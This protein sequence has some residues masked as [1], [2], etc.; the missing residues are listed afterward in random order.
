MYSP[1]FNVNIDG[2]LAIAIYD[3]ATISLSDSTILDFS[4]SP[5]VGFRSQSDVSL[6]VQPT[7]YSR[8]DSD[9]TGT[10]ATSSYSSHHDTGSPSPRNTPP[11]SSTHVPTPQPNTYSHLDSDVTGA[12]A[13]SSYSSHH[14]TGSPS[15]PYGSPAS[16]THVPTPQYHTI[17]DFLSSLEDL[18]KPALLSIANSHIEDSS[19]DASQTLI[20]F[21]IR[22]LSQLAPKLSLRALRRILSQNSVAHNPNDSRPQL[23][24]ELKKFITRLKHGKRSEERRNETIAAEESLRARHQEILNTWPKIVQKDLKDKIINLFRKET[25]K[26]AL[27][28]FTYFMHYLIPILKDH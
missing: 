7:T 26:D 13:T 14:D 10:D 5:R 18:R 12:D 6:F 9:V 19:G 22:I 15:P 21:K 4:L 24:R 1:S 23:R 27:A 25:S 11:T 20:D 2:S 8:L 28:T 17:H 3:G 16:S